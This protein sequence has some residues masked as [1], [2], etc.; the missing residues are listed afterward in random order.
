MIIEDKMTVL[1]DGK[2]PTNEVPFQYV[3]TP[4]EP[5]DGTRGYG[6]QCMLYRTTVVHVVNMLRRTTVLVQLIWGKQISDFG[7][8]L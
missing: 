2:H 6:M 8:Y 1:N 4:E 3:S 5:S 7:I